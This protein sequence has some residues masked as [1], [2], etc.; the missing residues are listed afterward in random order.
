MVRVH[1]VVYA[2]VDMEVERALGAADVDRGAPGAL[3][4]ADEELRQLPRFSWC[5][6]KRGV[7]RALALAEQGDLGREEPAGAAR[8]PDRERKLIHVVEVAPDADAGVGKVLER[9]GRAKGETGCL[10]VE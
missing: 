1:D 4:R 6:R 9:V 8:H 5:S 3:D 7:D 2:R 10:G